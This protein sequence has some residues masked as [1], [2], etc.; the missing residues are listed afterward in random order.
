MMPLGL[1]RNYGSEGDS[2]PAPLHREASLQHCSQALLSGPPARTPTGSP[3]SPG[4]HTARPARLALSWPLSSWAFLL[5]PWLSFHFVAS[6]L[7]NPQTFRCYR[8]L[9]WAPSFS[10]A[11]QG[12]PGEH[13][14]VLWH[15]YHLQ[16]WAR[17]QVSHSLRD[18]LAWTLERD[19]PHTQHSHGDPPSKHFPPPVFLTSTKAS[20]FNLVPEW[21]Y[22]GM[23]T[24]SPPSLTSHPA[25]LPTP[26][27]R[28]FSLHPH[29]HHSST[30]H[31]LA[32]CSESVLQLFPS[33]CPFIR[34]RPLHRQPPEA[35][36]V[37]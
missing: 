36:E 28:A 2:Y 32:R 25:Q 11:V 12:L 17:T 30:S 7:L 33:Q 15:K 18:I 31:C 22:E 19:W 4:Q 34:V 23:I 1:S 9:C 29:G 37:F 8:A 35:R 20:P 10:P 3:P 26:R 24:N 6:P 27:I 21:K 5:P 13:Q 16:S 14:P